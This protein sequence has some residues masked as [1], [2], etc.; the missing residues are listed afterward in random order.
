MNCP[1]C[2][3]E[4]R[5]GANYCKNCGIVLSEK[6]V[7]QYN[8]FRMNGS[9]KIVGIIVILLS[10]N[11]FVWFFGGYNFL[12]LWDKKL[13]SITMTIYHFG[14]LVLLGFYCKHEILRIIAVFLAM[15]TLIFQLLLQ[16]G[17]LNFLL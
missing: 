4:N 17:V 16:F 1:Q 10:L 12:N 14:L 6:I 11:T 2:E 8:Q 13:I 5:N 3:Y 9:N 7:H 15:L